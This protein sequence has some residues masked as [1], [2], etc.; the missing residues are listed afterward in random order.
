M[1]AKIVTHIFTNAK[2]CSIEKLL[3]PLREKEIHRKLCTVG[4][5]KYFPRT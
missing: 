5:G 1:H 2:Y 4:I 3:E